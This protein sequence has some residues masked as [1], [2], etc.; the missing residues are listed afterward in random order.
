VDLLEIKKSDKVLDLGCGHGHT[1]LYIT[2]KLGKNGQAI[3]LDVGER[4]LAVAER[5]M[6]DEI[7]NGKLELIKSNASKELPFPNGS[8]NKIVCHNVIECIPDKINFI[9]ECFRI[10]KKNGILVMSHNDFDTQIYNSSFPDLSRKLVHNYCDTEQEWMETSDGMIG[11][12][13]SGIFHKTKF[14]NTEVKTYMVN[15]TKFN[16]FEYGYSSAYNIIDIAKKLKKFKPAE[17]NKWLEDLKKKDKSGDYFY[18]I[19]I[20]LIVAKK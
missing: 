6:K 4:L 20:Y 14:K 1:L 19:N 11:R 9:N 17:L 7:S 10:L 15:N 3:G 8:F 18:S 5:V 13:L 2:Q 12:K 16:Q